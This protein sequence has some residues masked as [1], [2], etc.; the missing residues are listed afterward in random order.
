MA[1]SEKQIDAKYFQQIPYMQDFGKQR[2][3]DMVAVTPAH[4]EPLGIYAKRVKSLNEVPQNAINDV[5]LSV[6]RG[7]FIVQAGMKPTKH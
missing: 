6:I 2:G 3:I 4:I 7:N 5:D 1:L